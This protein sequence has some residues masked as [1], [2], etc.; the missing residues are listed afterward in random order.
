VPGKPDRPELQ[1]ASGSLQRVSTKV[2]PPLA[3]GQQGSPRR[4]Q[5]QRPAW[6]LPKA[7]SPTR[8]MSPAARH[9]PRRQQLSPAHLLP[10]QH[11][12]PG[13]PHF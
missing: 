13:P 8:Q 3:V 10:V 7:M 12:S 6:Q 9:W 2:L 4:P 5:P 11:G 1:A